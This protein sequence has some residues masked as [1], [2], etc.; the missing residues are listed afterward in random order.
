MRTQQLLWHM[1]SVP[2]SPVKPLP[3]ARFVVTWSGR[4]DCRAAWSPSWAT[5]ASATQRA[6][7]AATRPGP[8]DPHPPVANPLILWEWFA[9][10]QPA[11]EASLR[12]GDLPMVARFDEQ[13]FRA[14]EP[15][16]VFDFGLRCLLDGIEVLLE[17]T[18][19]IR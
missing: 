1:E 7:P 12:A 11:I 17:Q 16:A 15:D 10:R 19:A 13:T 8:D 14:T 3:C 18:A 6:E 9:A 4:A 2:G 5:G